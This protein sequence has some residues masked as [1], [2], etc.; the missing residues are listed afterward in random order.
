M[1]LVSVIVP[2]YNARAWVGDALRSVA[3]QGLDDL[4]VI[5]VDDGS[6]DGSAD[7]VSRALPAARLLRTANGGPSRARNLGTQ[8]AAGAF[9]QY[10]DADDELA[11]GKLRRQLAALEQSGAEVAYGDWERLEPGPDGAY[12]PAGLVEREL[13]GEAELALLTDFWCPPAAYLFRRSVVERVGGWHEGLPVIQ[14]AR[15]ALDCALRGARFVRA[16]GLAARYRAHRSGSVGTRS[17][18]GLWRDC[19]RNAS[20]VEDWWRRHGGVTPGRRAALLAVY[21]NVAHNGFYLAGDLFRDGCRG[22]ERVGLAGLPPHLR[23]LRMLSDLL[24][25]R[26]ARIAA[27]GARG[28]RRAGADLRRRTARA[29]GRGLLGCGGAG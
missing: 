5:V 7:V 14:D 1:T 20:E 19:Q 22:V 2:C 15:F 24:G 28:L 21:G 4:E 26:A 10:L 23:R 25:Y 16:P 13:A 6:T 29:G 17:Q 11:P 27:R 12:R 18:L 8:L 9:I 3:E